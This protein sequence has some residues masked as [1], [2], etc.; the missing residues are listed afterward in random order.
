MGIFKRVKRTF[1]ADI[2][3][4]ID[5]MENPVS[6]VKQY[7]RE[8]EEQLA[9]GKKEIAQQ[10]VVEKKYSNLI[11][12]TQALIEKRTRQANLAVS[13]GDD[14]VARLALQEKILAEQ[15]LSSY[16]QQYQ[17]VQ[18]KTTELVNKINGLQ[19][20]YEELALR[21]NELISRANVATTLSEINQTTTSYRAD[22]AIHGFARMEEKVWELEAA[23]QTNS[24]IAS[25]S[26]IPQINPLLAN[27]VEEELDKLKATEAN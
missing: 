20:K 10:Y 11:D 23:S 27:D 16:Q 22:D 1:T 26:T 13:K 21:K 4:M 25:R 19:Q 17:L 9:K 12:A 7:L 8:I 6:L 3:E 24:I 18:E 14:E 5:K 15:K 2:N